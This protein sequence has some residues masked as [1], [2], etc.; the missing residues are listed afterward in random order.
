M[1]SIEERSRSLL[2]F[3]VEHE[4]EVKK[5]FGDP[6]LQ[7]TIS[8]P[9]NIKIEKNVTLTNQVDDE[10]YNNFKNFCKDRNIKVK[11][12]LMRAMLDLMNNY[13]DFKK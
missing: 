12:A 7:K 3:L 13:K 9:F 5:L 6:E 4:E 10:V 11:A 2:E 8:D 1:K